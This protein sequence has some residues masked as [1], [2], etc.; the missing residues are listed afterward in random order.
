MK[1]LGGINITKLLCLMFLFEFLLST[2]VPLSNKNKM[3]ADN[4]S[5]CFAPCI[6]WAKERSMKDI[7]YATKSVKIV[8]MMLKNF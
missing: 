4:L 7:G 1:Q 5:I 8:S 2:I 3:T 6:M